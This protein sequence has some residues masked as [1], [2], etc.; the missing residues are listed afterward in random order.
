M[1]KKM[2][3]NIDLSGNQILGA[4]FEK[5]TTDP[6]SGNFKGRMYFNTTDNIIK[7][8]DGTS[9][10]PV[11]D[12]TD[13]QGTTNEVE[14][15][16]SAAG[17]AT[18][19]LPNTI[20]AELHGNASTATKWATG[21]KITL[22]GD[23]SG[24][25]TI[26][27]SQDV[28][29]TATIGANSIELGTDTTGDYVATI[30]GTDGVSISG[31]G[32]E[33]RAVT[34]ANTDKGSSQNIFKN[35]A[36][37]GQS[38]IVAD[39]NNDTLTVESGTGISITTNATTDTL[40]IG[41]SGVTALSGT[42][43]QISASGSTG[44]V[45][46]SLPNAVTFPGTVTLNADPSA[47]L[48]AAT[49]QYVDAKVNGLTWK[50]A[51][52]VLSATNVPLTGSTPLV[53]DSHTLS[54]GYRVVLTNQTTGT[55][56]GIYNL[57]IASG[58]Y[59][60]S[61]AADG[62]AYTEL[63]GVSIFIEEGTTYAKTSWV[64]SNH[65]LTDFADQSWFQI[66][67]QGAY[68][69]GNGLSIS[70]GQ[71]S[72]DT[73]I[74]VDKNTAQTLTNK[75]LTSPTVSG[76]YLSDNSIVIEGAVNDGAETT[77]TFTNPTDDRTI[78]FKDASGTVAFL[79]DIPSTTDGLTEGSTNLYFTDERAQDAVGGMLVDGT[80]IDF[81]YDDATPSITAEVKLKSSNSYLST[82]SG[83]NVDISS[84][85]TKLVTDGFTKKA[86]AN[87]GNS[88]NTSFAITHNLGTRDVQVQIYDN[89]TYDTVECDV[90]RTSTTVVT[91]SFATAPN[92]D[93]YR[94][95]VIG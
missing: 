1:A 21:R 89:D 55:Q 56:N 46:L 25:V 67:G 63:V 20:Y 52:N 83:L 59:T 82:T 33:G 53:V 93:A 76:L 50:Q 34:I 95:V 57:A 18:I 75:T 42:A 62:D 60:L 32:T 47:D 94:V 10:G 80:T 71:F 70:G 68:T 92:T 48:Q 81:T 43:N 37:S 31:T 74:T 65:Y 58:S 64:Q 36:V 35:V 72:I 86:S 88:T 87:V 13:V 27:G 49:K 4:S 40:T 39:T 24:D 12:I 15:S 14:V 45:T 22:G 41:N 17:V 77:L 7:V 23:L 54:D 6:V 30:G 16:V 69:A 28:T 26:D 29:L 51:A 79:S 91:V 3:T 5:L 44:S 9:W 90:V 61:R 38:D 19:G 85:E 84:V 73:T 78:T 66:S 2:L 8:Y 11:G